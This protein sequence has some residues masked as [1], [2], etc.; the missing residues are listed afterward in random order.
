MIYGGKG[1]SDSFV[2]FSCAS[3]RALLQPLSTDGGSGSFTLE[4]GDSLL[5]PAECQDF[6]LVPA[7]RDTVLLETTTYRVEPD[8]YI[9]PDVPA[10][11]PE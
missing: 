10:Y 5:V 9:N 7:D 2:L 6:S 3:G 8:R 4:A 11:L 1:E